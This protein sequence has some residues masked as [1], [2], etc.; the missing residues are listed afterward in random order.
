M[1]G[2]SSNPP[3]SLKHI[4]LE[5]VQSRMP[6]GADIRYALR[7]LGRSPMFSVTAVLSLAIGIAASTAIF[8]L[9]DALIFR[10]RSGIA[11]PERVVDIG[12]SVRGEGF[13][14]LGYP[15]FTALR[16]RNTTLAGM[17]A[18][19]HD[20]EVMGLGDGQ[21]AER[22][23]AGMVSGN[24][25]ELL[26]TRAAAGRFFLPEEDRTPGTHPVAVL[27]HAFWTR[28]FNAD[29]TIVG[30]TMRLNGMPY[31]IVGV[32]EEGFTGTG[33]IGTD[34]WV[35]FAMEQHVRSADASLLA[36]NI[37]VWHVALGRL[38]PGVTP[39][40]AHEELTAIMRNFIYVPLAQQFRPQITFYVRRAGDAS[41]IAAMRQVVR[42]FDPA[43]PV[44]FAQ[45]LEDATALGL[46]P[47]HL[48][49]WVSA[50]VGSAGVLLAALGLY[51]LTAFAVAQRT[52]EIAVRMALG[53]S[54]RSILALVLTQS[55]RLAAFGAGVG[56][57]LAMAVGGALQNL[58]NG[59]APIDPVAFASATL[60][61]TGVLLAASWAPARRASRMD[62]MR[63]LRAE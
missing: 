48:A 42:D 22:V 61:L 25:F 21:S 16:E 63:A 51:G 8:S 31:T 32:A 10:P 20:P 18:V 54:R 9:A 43:L 23:Y 2:F 59:V 37:A 15:L 27:T 40:Q 1:N 6:I 28:R 19:R 58:L 11:E 14:N 35:P 60:L 24:F 13:D 47:Q 41:Q 44:I 56:L 53:A 36:N 30:T 34:F 26:G 29:P 52:R 38:K 62:P 12:R 55:G 7:V 33:I 50:S 46:V 3:R 17:S 4:V 45:T 49:A 57:L 39:A 5:A